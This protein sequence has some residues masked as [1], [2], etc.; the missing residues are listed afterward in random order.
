MVKL[1]MSC[2]E[3]YAV[4]ALH[5]GKAAYRAGVDRNP[6]ADG[7]RESMAWDAGWSSAMDWEH[8]RSLLL[9]MHPPVKGRRGRQHG[10]P[11]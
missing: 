10:E 9:L 4:D 6:H 5:E 3:E 1:V 8:Q 7:S 11:Q 2:I